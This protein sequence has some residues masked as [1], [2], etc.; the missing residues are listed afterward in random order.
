[1]SYPQPDANEAAVNGANFFRL[2]T[3]L[4]SPGDI[5]ESEQG[6]HAF[7]I[8]PKSDVARVTIVY[9]DDNKGASEPRTFMT[10]T[11]ISPERALVGLVVAK[12]QEAS[13]QPAD[14]PGRILFYVSDLYDDRYRPEDADPVEGNFLRVIPQLDVIQY[15][16]PVNSLTPGRDDKTFYFQ[17]I[18]PPV[19]PFDTDPTYVIL[20][21]FGRK[22]AFIEMTNWDSVAPVTIKII[23][24]NYAI[25]NDFLVGP[26]PIHQET[27]LLTPT[28]LAASGGQVIKLVRASIE[29]MF[30]ALVISVTGVG[31]RTPLK[32]VMSDNPL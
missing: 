14:R 27:V 9:W 17:V 28:V 15:F 31:G 10:S 20:P 8:G 5:Y 32:I 12:N 6:A 21:Y 26:T 3:P 22:Y 2:N 7:A 1:V 23:G 18:P 24:T 29:G 16:Q 19:A 13:Y 25:T 4:V 30:D 11:E